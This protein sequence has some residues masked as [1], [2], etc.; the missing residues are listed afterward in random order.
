MRRLRLVEGGATEPVSR[1]PGHVPRWARNPRRAY[2]QD[3]REITPV[4]VAAMRAEGVTVVMAYCEEFYCGHSAK[5]DV[6]CWPG[7]IYVPDIGL[8][9]RCSA[10][11]VLGRS[12]IMP[13][14]RDWR[15]ARDQT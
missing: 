3:G 7:E 4:T 9:L 10:C 14:H 15:E 8:R 6:S 12:R 5:V 13:E 1:N 11:R 2:D